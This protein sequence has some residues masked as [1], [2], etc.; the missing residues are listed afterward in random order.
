MGSGRVGA[1]A[2]GMFGTRRRR[3][4]QSHDEWAGVFVTSHTL[5]TEGE[6]GAAMTGGAEVWIFNGERSMFPSAVFSTRAKAEAWIAEN[7]LSGTLTNYPVDESAYDWACRNGRFDPA[8]EMSP[9]QIATFSPAMP[10]EH[11]TDGKKTV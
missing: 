8:R 4:R 6:E 9:R 7:R 10:H 1:T 5:G 3:V 2:F 11:Y